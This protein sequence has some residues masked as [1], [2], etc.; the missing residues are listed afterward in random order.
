[1]AI[2]S[3]G[4]VRRSA[5]GWVGLGW[6]GVVLLS[7]ASQ[8]DDVGITWDEPRYFE[9]VERIQA[10]SGRVARL[11]F[12]ALRA[13]EIRAAWDT[14]RYY[15]PH[16]PAY[17]I[18]MAATSA[19]AG[20]F[21][22]DIPGYRLSTLFA[23]ALLAAAVSASIARLVG[24]LAGFAAGAALVLMP[25]VYGH[26]LIGATDIPLTVWWFVGTIG[27]TAFVRG[28]SR[29]WLVIGGL[30][31]GLGFATKFTAFL[32]P[33]PIV[34]WMLLC[35]RSRRSVTALAYGLALAM[36]VAVIVNPAAWPDPIGYQR[37]LIHES[38]G[39]EGTI[40]ISTFYLARVWA[41]DLPWH[42]APLMTLATVPAAVA[43]LAVVSLRELFAAGDRR[44]WVVLCLVQVAFWWA[45]MALPGSPNH[46][47]V[48]L[49]LPMFPFV[50][51]LA[52]IGFSGLARALGRRLSDSTRVVGLIAFAALVFLP[53]AFRLASARPYYLAEY[54]ELVGGTRGAARLGLEATYWFDAVTRPF[55]D[56]LN[57]DLPAG[58]L[59]F[60]YPNTE[61]YEQLQ[62]LG[63]LRPD[64]RFTDE[65]PADFLLLLAR[66]AMFEPRWAAVY[67]RSSPR[68]AVEH[69]GV[70]LVGLYD[71]DGEPDR[72]IET[73]VGEAP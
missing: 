52:G 17:K 47:G 27:L 62:G 56:R 64:L 22:G 12:D 72:T 7:G 24:P 58:A 59:V 2:A 20:P 61:Y 54:G 63:L 45:V 36:L 31:M 10:W 25:R 55:R 67:E 29:R 60:T 41:F 42:H 57:L 37:R 35:G 8:L 51:V 71:W 5:A 48:R 69:D 4:P 15:N 21:I 3:T 65:P 18:G 46:D 68:L 43:G 49:W 44:P 38:M 26:G 9:S 1:M 28:G 73:E 13:D 14:D 16:P 23:F 6:A 66:K 39:R 34:A 40:P 11:E 33:V 30:A 19:A 70:E 50:A 32:A 53:P